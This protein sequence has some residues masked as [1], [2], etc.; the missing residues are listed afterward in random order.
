MS[1]A[2]HPNDEDLSA[3]V[4][5]AAADDVGRHVASCPRC[6]RR[7]EELRTVSVAVAQ[8]PATMSDEARAAGLAAAMAASVAAREGTPGAVDHT[9]RDTGVPS[10]DAARR[11]RRVSRPGRGWPAWLPAAAVVLAVLVGV[12]L[13]LRG[14]GSSQKKTTTTAGS[15]RP[16]ADA[17]DA[18]AS[19]GGI[20][21]SKAAA[22]AA[23]GSTAVAGG[24]LGAQSDA[25]ALA[26][27]AS[28]DYQRRR[29]AAEGTEA[30]SPSA[31]FATAAGQSP[32]CPA[33][34]AVPAGAV[35]VYTA[36][37]RWNGSPARVFGYQAGGGPLWFDVTPVSD[38]TVLAT[39]QP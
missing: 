29:A 18:S 1:P 12:P 39:A 15:A 13:L 33:G 34:P 23:P 30:G 35:H 19:A 4:D 17:G 37:V 22:P 26:A 14:G 6:N 27:L 36:S 3:Y 10:L 32:A 31:P 7:V 8:P 21:S 28:A 2:T 20:A 16:T 24:D 38:C 9:T 25:R 5:G 11:S